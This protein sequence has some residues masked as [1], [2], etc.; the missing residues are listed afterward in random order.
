MPPPGELPDVPCDA[1]RQLAFGFDRAGVQLGFHEWKG[2]AADAVA[3]FE[4][5]GS[6]SARIRACGSMMAVPVCRGCGRPDLTH[7]M[8]SAD[9]ESRVCPS[10]ARDG[11]QRRRKRLRRAMRV[12]PVKRRGQSWW[13][14]T[15]TVRKPPG[16]SVERI[17]ADA[18]TAWAGWKAAWAVMKVQGA[19]AAHAELEVS[20]GGLV[21]IHV[22]VRSPFL[23]KDVLATLRSVVVAAGCG[24]QY[25]VKRV[26]SQKGA[27][28]EVAKYLTKGVARSDGRASQTHP[29]LAAMVDVA[30]RGRRTVRE[31]GTLWRDLPDDEDP[32]APA[33]PH[34][35]CCGWTLA[36]LSDAQ[37]K[38]L[39]A[40][41]G[42]GGGGR[43]PEVRNL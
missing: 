41:E 36:Y 29:L 31:Y 6:R 9:C 33:C 14:H 19:T 13:L 23:Q 3:W 20:P 21:H 15:L 8:V 2:L 22:L 43:R 12:Y 28:A 38:A 4:G 27:S 42:S 11:A 39:R 37:W 35:G 7:A 17:V 1:R 16:T 10:C 34:C 24:E 5:T 32:A 25:N 18:E 40:R 30:L 26:K